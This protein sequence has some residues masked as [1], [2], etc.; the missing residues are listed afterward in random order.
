MFSTGLSSGAREGKKTGVMFPGMWS[1]PVVCQPARSTKRTAWARGAPGQGYL[2]QVGLHGMGIG[3]WHDQC[4][5]ASP[6]RTD[7]AKNI[8]VLI[9]LILG[10]AGPG[11][12]P[13][14]LAYQTV[15]LAQSHLVL[16]P[17]FDAGVG[18]Q[19]PYGHR[20]RAGEVFL[21]SSITT[22]SCPGWRGRAEIWEKPICFSKRDTE[23]A[24][25][26]M[27]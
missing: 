17:K 2:I 12:T 4:R 10:L 9:P 5:A 26:I 7:G 15:L 22:S 24:I 23:P 21:K 13:R 14:P 1:S 8:C 16:P 19:M 18:R 3:V 11:S 6:S 27:V 25:L 20:Q